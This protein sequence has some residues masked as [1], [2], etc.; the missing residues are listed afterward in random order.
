MVNN[1]D[2]KNNNINIYYNKKYLNFSKTHNK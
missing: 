2:I 1:L